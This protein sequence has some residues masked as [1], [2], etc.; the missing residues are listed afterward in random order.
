MTASQQRATSAISMRDGDSREHDVGDAAH[1]P[2]RSP[3]TWFGGK[4]H[5]ARRI[6]PLLPPHECYVEPCC[7]SCPH[8]MMRALTSLR[9]TAG[10][11]TIGW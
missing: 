8:L 7:G 2:L 9:A 6:V 10:G 11:A 3:V 5:L 4:G 1:R